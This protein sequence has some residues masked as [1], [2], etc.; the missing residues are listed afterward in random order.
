M[1]YICSVDAGGAEILSAWVQSKTGVKISAFLEGPAVDIVKANSADIA[2][3][4]K[5][6]I[7][8][9]TDTLVSTL[10][11]S[12]DLERQCLQDA[13]T[14]GAKT[15]AMIEHWTNYRARLIYNGRLL[16]PDELW[17]FDEYAMQHAHQEL[18]EIDKTKIKL[19]P[20]FYLQ[21]IKD[22]FE[23]R[24]EPPTSRY[25]LYLSE[26]VSTH[27]LKKYGD[28]NALRYT[29]YTALEYLLTDAKRLRSQSA[30]KIRL[31]PSEDK[32]KYSNFISTQPNV[33]I[34]EFESLFED[35]FYADRVFGCETMA[36]VV[37]L[38]LGKQVYSVIPPGG[39]P[40]V[41]PH[42]RIIK[43]A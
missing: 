27:A 7:F 9:S 35:I 31:H 1:L 5:K 29:E 6:P 15:Y 8:N 18:P 42:S 40:C 39:R 13:I 26:P 33:S 3:L 14:A 43:S 32:K 41:L 4:H 20:N 2:R 19:K 11:W 10:S 16:I 34:S 23:A 12:S 25:D 37:A 21:N 36:M 22:S 38:E 17:V 30:L 24:F 28:P